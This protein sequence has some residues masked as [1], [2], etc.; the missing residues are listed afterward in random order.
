VLRRGPRS[1][2]CCSMSSMQ[3]WGRSNPAN[4]SRGSVWTPLVFLV[5]LGMAGCST[6]GAD[7]SLKVVTHT[8]YSSGTAARLSGKLAVDSAGCVTLQLPQGG[9]QY[10]AFP[11]KFASTTSDSLTFDGHAYRV[12]EELSVGGGGS[13][14]RADGLDVPSGCPSS[15]LIFV[16]APTP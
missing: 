2:L 3:F 14:D 15:G 10:L 1:Q 16:S 7:G 6:G 5:L 9:N 13:A 4:T 11:R 12:G 8:N